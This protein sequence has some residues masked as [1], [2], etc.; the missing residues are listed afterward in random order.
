MRADVTDELLQLNKVTQDILVVPVKE[1]GHQGRLWKLLKPIYGLE[2][3]GRQWYR[4]I[5]E[6]L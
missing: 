1:A 3:S 4:T 2:D 6:A 5:A